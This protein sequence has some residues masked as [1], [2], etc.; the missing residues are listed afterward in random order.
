MK[1]RDDD[2]IFRARL[3]YLGPPGHT[4]PIHLPYAQWGVG[5]LLTAVFSIVLVA[6][7]GDWLWIGAA[8]GAAIA[9]TTYI[10]RFVDPDRPARTVVRTA[11]LD[12]KSIQPPTDDRLPRL[13]A[14]VTIRSEITKDQ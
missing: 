2:D 12:A 1:V 3:L 8:L 6:L 14:N 13:V 10:W 5:A 4:F 7:T 11:L 9:V